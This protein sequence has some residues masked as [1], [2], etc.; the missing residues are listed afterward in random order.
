[1]KEGR[2]LRGVYSS[3][4]ESM[5]ECL[6]VNE[7][8]TSLCGEQLVEDEGLYAWHACRR[9]IKIWILISEMDFRNV[10]VESS[11][12]KYACLVLPYKEKAPNEGLC[13]ADEYKGTV[14]FQV[15]RSM[16]ATNEE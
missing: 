16:L 11:D 2:E 13:T 8:I 4:G 6:Q 15:F 12:V 9:C 14:D 7:T 1:M 5:C 10:V 3:A